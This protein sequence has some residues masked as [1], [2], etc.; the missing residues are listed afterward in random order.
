MLGASF[1]L[2]SE[3]VTSN[4]TGLMW[5]DNSE[6]KNTKKDW[7]GAVSY[8]SELSLAGHSDWRLP[9]IKELQSITDRSKFGPKIKKGFNHVASDSYWSS[10]VYA[11][12]KK[13]AWN[14]YFWNARTTYDDKTDE[15]YIRCVRARQ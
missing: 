6:S 1:L 13:H 2:A 8:C 11:S 5:Q 12:S 15:L 3:T 7:D 14:V 10:S 4:S 9:N